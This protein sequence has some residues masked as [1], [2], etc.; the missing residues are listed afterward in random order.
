MSR[1]VRLIAV[2][3]LLP[4]ALACSKPG[5]AP[6]DPNQPMLEL[7][8]VH[9]PE[10]LLKA[11]I[12]KPPPASETSKFLTSKGKLC[13]RHP[14]VGIQIEFR[15]DGTWT[16]SYTE[17]PAQAEGTWVQEP[18][19]FRLTLNGRPLGCLADIGA[20]FTDKDGTPFLVA[21]PGTFTP[22]P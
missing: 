6:P 16:E 15:A 20:G 18:E 3:A 21:P 17:P 14:R 4:G 22:C 19:C 13:S 8:K 2:L 1:P 12:I 10:K 9:T 7:L 5:G 11:G